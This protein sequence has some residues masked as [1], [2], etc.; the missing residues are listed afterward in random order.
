MV[1]AIFGFM[2]HWATFIGTGQMA[3]VEDKKFSSP[4]DVQREICKLPSGAWRLTDSKITGSSEN[5]PVIFSIRCAHWTCALAFPLNPTSKSVYVIF[6]LCPVK[7]ME[8]KTLRYNI[9]ASLIFFTGKIILPSR[10]LSIE[11]RLHP[12]WPSLKV[13]AFFIVSKN[14]RVKI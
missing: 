9:I 4:I 3:I 12:S 11:E 13:H 5:L 6:C 14:A 10:S 7:G 8:G 2:H 1:Q